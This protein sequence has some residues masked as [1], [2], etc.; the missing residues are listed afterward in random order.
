MDQWLQWAITTIVG[1]LGILAGRFWER[2]DRKLNKDRDLINKIVSI[3]PID[4]ESLLAL[5]ENVYANPYDV[6]ELESLWK[7]EK[8]L[9]QPSYFF[10]DNKLEKNKFG[11]MM[12]IGDFHN[13]IMDDRFISRERSE[14]YYFIKYP[15]EV[16]T[17]EKLRQDGQFSEEEI[18]QIIEEDR[19][20]FYGAQHSLLSLSMDVCDKYDAL[21]INA[22]KIL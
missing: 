13:F 8:L 16:D 5:R 12:A 17:M 10:L 3:V 14:N 2:F 19:H 7:L 1:I 20:H 4:S 6:E 21:M 9:R 11:L 22:H 18:T 15:D